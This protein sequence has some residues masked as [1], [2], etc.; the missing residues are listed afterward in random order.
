MSI[1]LKMRPIDAG[2]AWRRSITALWAAGLA[3][4]LAVPDIASAQSVV[5]RG[6]ADKPIEIDADNLE[7]QQAN[8]LA[9]FTGNV[10]AT[11]GQIK[12]RADQI[13]VW[14]QPDGKSNGSA[15]ATGAITRI[16]A[17]GNVFVSS[18]EETAQGDNGVYDVPAK[19]ITLTGQVVL[20][21]GENVIRGQQLV[22]NME[23]GRSQVQGGGGRVR[24][25]FVPS[26]DEAEGA[27][28]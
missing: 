10:E 21:R 12:L 14:Y 15:D 27:K 18:L 7:V 8:N 19:T 26:R 2:M 25:L 11:Q 28:K 3:L 16:D 20:T 13:K 23:T 24:G 1:R 6:D 17:I 9:I 22:L 5:P 4:L